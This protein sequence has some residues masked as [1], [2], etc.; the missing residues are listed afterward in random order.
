[1]GDQLMEEKA[2]NEEASEQ[3][4]IAFQ[5][6]SHLFTRGSVEK[7]EQIDPRHPKKHRGLENPVQGK[8]GPKGKGSGETELLHLLARLVLRQEVEIQTIR[9]QDSFVFHLSVDK[10]GLLQVLLDQGVQWGQQTDKTMPLR[11]HLFQQM[12]QEL[13][14]RFE[15]VRQAPPQSPT[16]NKLQEQQIILKDG[17]WPKLQW[18]PDQQ[19]FG[20]A[21]APSIPMTQMQSLIAELQEMAADHAQILR[22]YSMQQPGSQKST[23]PWKL[24]LRL[25]ADRSM[26]VMMMLEHS[27]IWMLMGATMKHHTPH[28]S[29]LSQQ[30]SSFLGKGTKSGKG[31]GKSKHSS[32]P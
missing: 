29:T 21:K 12:T 8:E 16:W 25:R 10:A 14:K 28:P 5:H 22:F 9:A 20:L 32:K 23:V 31:K 26:E 15:V 30:V 2:E 11:A 27:T 1:M 24:Q 6:L 19:K 13:L 4:R 18:L 7:I 3:L 17:S